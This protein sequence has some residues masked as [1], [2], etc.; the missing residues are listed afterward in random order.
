MA[1]GREESWAEH[2]T[3]IQDLGRNQAAPVGF[4]YQGEQGEKAASECLGSVRKLNSE[5]LQRD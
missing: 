3:S 4:K 5:I 1:D 2:F